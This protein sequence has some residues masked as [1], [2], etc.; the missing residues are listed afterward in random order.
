VR[1]IRNQLQDESVIV[2]DQE[3][4]DEVRNQ[5]QEA[6][7]NFSVEL[8]VEQ[9][10]IPV[11]S[12]TSAN[13]E[14]DSYGVSDVPVGYRETLVQYDEMNLFFFAEANFLAEPS[15]LHHEL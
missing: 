15:F 11:I 5:L 10:H 3:I 14:Q 7:I 1:L 4:L 2:I 13:L 8:V 12:E 9:T 6:D